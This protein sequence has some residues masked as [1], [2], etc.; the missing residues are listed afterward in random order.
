MTVEATVTGSNVEATVTDGGVSAQIS[1]PSQ[2][3][4]T[5]SGEQGPP[6]RSL[7]FLGEW[8]DQGYEQNDVVEFEGS[9]YVCL[10]T[11]TS[12][13]AETPPENA[14][15]WAI[16]AEGFDEAPTD[17]VIY[18]R[19][20]GEWVDMTG[21][22]NLQF[23][24]G[25]S[26]EVSAI[27][28]EAAE[29]VWVT[30]SKIL[31]I[32]DGSTQGGIPSGGFPLSGTKAKA[33]Q[34]SPQNIV[35]G[36]AIFVHQD[37]DLYTVTYPTGISGGVN[38][39]VA[40]AARGA[41][42]VDFTTSRTSSAQVASGLNSFAGPG[43]A[44]ASATKSVAFHG[45]ASAESAVTFGGTASGTGSVAF[46]GTASQPNTVS[47]NGDADVA[48][49]VAHGAVVNLN[50]L[51][52]RGQ[53]VQVGMRWQTSNATPAYLRRQGSAIG[54]PIPS[55]V[56][57]FGIA[58]IC[59]IQAST[60]TVVC[61]YIRKFAIKNTGGTTALIGSPT[62]IGTDEESDAG[63]DVDIEANDS[64]DALDIKVTGIASTTLRW[65]AVVNAVQQAF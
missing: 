29:P 47:L 30:D 63:L 35:G 8:T 27:V 28:P 5:A 52:G 4:A 26:A 2:V 44:T 57:M 39:N 24:S 17:G 3:A 32:G 61:H 31:V 18:G 59:A 1:N 10:V 53:A 36:G 25:T 15:K 22:A 46:G 55:G 20:N 23:R 37:A 54:I 14:E 38:P 13:P 50:S 41:G 34:A 51:I 11:F 21:E 16:L 58:Q 40:G 56:A 6:G 19:R 9:S 42:A 64:T 45:T 43:T 60:G 7:R 48:G 33:E 65:I 12:N 49:M 62:T